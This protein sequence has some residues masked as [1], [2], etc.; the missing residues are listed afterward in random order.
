MQNMRKKLLLVNPSDR[1]AGLAHNTVMNWPP[2]HMMTLA[3]GVSGDWD[4]EI[5]DENVRQ[6]DLT[7]LEADLVGI[8]TGFTCQAPRAYQLATHLRSKGVPVLIGGCHASMLPDEAARYADSVVIGEADELLGKVL[9]DFESGNLRPRY[10]AD[11]PDIT[12]LRTP[13]FDLVD[14]QNYHVMTAQNSRG[15]PFK[16]E[17]CS[18]TAFS[19]ATHRMKT[20]N[21]MYAEVMASGGAGKT[22]VIIDDNLLPG[23]RR[24]VEQGIRTFRRL[25]ECR[26][27]WACQISINVVEKPDL[28][29]AAVDSGGRVFY[30]G[31]ESLSTETLKEISKPF[32]VKH[33]ATGYRDAIRKLHDHGILV[34]GG[35]ILGNDRDTPDSLKRMAEFVWQ[36]EIDA[37][38]FQPLT[39]FPG[40]P[41]YD[42]LLRDGRIL[43][44]DY[45]N[46]WGRYTHDHVVFKPLH[47]TP[48]QLGEMTRD[49]YRQTATVWKSFRRMVK[50]VL[51]T[52]GNSKS[53]EVGL[54]N[55]AHGAFA[56]RAE[57]IEAQRQDRYKGDSEL[58]TLREAV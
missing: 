27:K 22:M 41:L 18:V 42:R 58:P 34:I 40:T 43:F 21:Q 52:G 49:L 13:R 3:A 14:R 2:L 55:Y 47:F 19:G 5:V 37:T 25:K 46:D 26:I 29:D 24:A 44:T 51:N 57:R 15:C 11:L 9:E 54:Y 7:S 45:P 39:P 48:D 35:L 31:L 12:R 53:F 36:S 16:C 50:S 56:K 30:I 23:G 10:K 6:K 8:T 4:V 28:L 38:E 1:N 33:A 17:F 32:N 20:E